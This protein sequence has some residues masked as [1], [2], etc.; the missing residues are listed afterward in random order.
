MAKYLRLR[1]PLRAQPPIGPSPRLSKGKLP[2]NKIVPVKQNDKK[3]GKTSVQ[4]P[5][6]S[7]PPAKI[8]PV[9][10]PSPK[11]V[12]VTLKKVEDEVM[13]IADLEDYVIVDIPQKRNFL[14]R[15]LFGDLTKTSA[16]KQFAIGGV[17]GW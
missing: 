2:G 5:R 15:I 8:P 1:Y 16:F 4:I 13:D 3:D 6:A 9:K 10:I 7:I 17:L 11:T 12:Q 14:A